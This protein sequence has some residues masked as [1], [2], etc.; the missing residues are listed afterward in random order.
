MK[1]NAEG[2]HCRRLN[3]LVHEAIGKGVREMTLENVRG[4]RY[5]GAGL[6]SG[7]RVNINGVPGNDL[8]AFLN[9]AELNVN[10]NGQDGIG[11]TMNSGRIVVHGDA[12][13]IPG[14][15]MRGGR[16]LIRGG[17]GYR[18][19]IHMK[20]YGE[21]VPVVV[22]GGAAMDYLGEYMAGGILVVLNLHGNPSGAAGACVGTGMHGGV[23]FV[24]G[25]LREHQVGAEVAMGTPSSEDCS[26]LK[27]ILHDYRAEIGDRDG[28]LRPEEFVKLYPR[29]GRPYGRLYAY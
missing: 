7:V 27:E 19:G 17:V 1:I 21:N 14:Y 5:I 8:G 16:I 24:R 3:E 9:G 22:I 26:V 15:A 12:G 29:T 20:A 18:A 11:N 28:R 4:Q 23:I 6:D 10:G 25:E 13:D 2:L